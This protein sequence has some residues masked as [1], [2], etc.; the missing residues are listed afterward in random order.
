MFIAIFIDE[1]FLKPYWDVI[2]KIVLYYMLA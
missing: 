1:I 2:T